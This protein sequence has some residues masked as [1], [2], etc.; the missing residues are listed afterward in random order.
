M[1]PIS[2]GESARWKV[3]TAWFIVTLPRMLRACRLTYNS[4]AAPRQAIARRSLPITAAPNHLPRLLVEQKK[5]SPAG[6]K[7]QGDGRA[8]RLI[9]DVDRLVLSALAHQQIQH[10]RPE[11]DGPHQH[12]RQKFAHNV[13]PGDAGDAEY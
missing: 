2:T 12:R 6:W 10:G 4:L 11:R 13:R 7:R 5:S 1:M 3:E 9:S 8:R